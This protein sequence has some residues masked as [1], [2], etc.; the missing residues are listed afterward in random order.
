MQPVALASILAVLATAPSVR[1]HFPDEGVPTHAFFLVEASTGKV[2]RAEG[3]DVL[4]AKHSWGDLRRVV[5]V[6]AGLEDG[7]LDAQR[8]VAC[9]S[10]CWALGGHGEVRLLD[11]LAWGCD[12]WYAAAFPEPDPV[13]FDR[14]ATALGL[15]VAGASD[16]RVTAEACVAFW[17]T[18][19]SLSLDLRADTSTQLLAVA[20]AS[21]SSPRGTARL[22]H[23]PRRR[24]RAF[25]CGGAEGAWAIGGRSVLGREWAFAVYLPGG[26]PALAAS[27]AARLLEDTRRVARRSTLERGGV[28]TDEP[29]DEP[30]DGG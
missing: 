17:R 1:E 29:G 6:A 18:L 22:L 5:V 3:G 30:R 19:A 25:V 13:T 7:R 20:G 4:E 26:T 11:G 15:R 23:D 8:V 10:T 14:V 27:R 16:E 2:V 12:T 24:T 21:V 28:A 9:D